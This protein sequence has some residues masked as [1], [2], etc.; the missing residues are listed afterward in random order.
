MRCF[1]QNNPTRREYRK[2]MIATWREIETFERTE[3]RFVDQGRVIRT[4]EL[5]TEAELE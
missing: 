3:Q 4:N 2:R 5:L 1:Y